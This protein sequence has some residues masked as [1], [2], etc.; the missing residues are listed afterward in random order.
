MEKLSCR[1]EQQKGFSLIEAVISVCAVTMGAL[2]LTSLQS[3]LLKSTTQTSQHAEAIVL[4]EDKLEQLKSY[5]TQAEYDAISSDQDEVSSVNTSYLRK[6]TVKSHT[7]P[8]YKLVDLDVSWVKVDGNTEHLSLAS[9]LSFEDVSDMQNI[10]QTTTQPERNIQKNK[11]YNRSTNQY[12]RNTNRSGN[13][14]RNRCQ[15]DK[16]QWSWLYQ[17]VKN[18]NNARIRR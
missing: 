16:R 12:N 18:Q 8:N 5:M 10:M 14:G 15:V 17:N 13:S 3:K 9:R 1:I 4:G 6:W 7:S 2:A 11:Q